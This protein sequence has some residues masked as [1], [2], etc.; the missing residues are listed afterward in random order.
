MDIY[1]TFRAA[2]DRELWAAIVGAAVDTK[3]LQPID[4]QNQ[5]QQT[6]LY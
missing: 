3:G 5:K 1:Y 4:Y 6:F 2:M